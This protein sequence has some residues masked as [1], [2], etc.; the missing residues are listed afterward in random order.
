MKTYASGLV[1]ALFLWPLAV[2]A[3]GGDSA[4]GGAEHAPGGPQVLDTPVPETSEGSVTPYQVP[5]HVPA[6]DP[7]QTGFASG[8]ILPDF[9]DSSATDQRSYLGALYVTPDQGLQGVHV[10]SVIPGSPAARA[11]F[12]GANTPQPKGPNWFR[13][14][15]FAL[16][17]SPA[18]AFAIPL[19][20]AHHVYTNRTVAAPVDLPGDLI[21]AVDDKP[22]RDAQAFSQVLSSYEPGTRVSFS[23][24]RA[25]KPLQLSATLEREPF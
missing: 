7:S 22:V 21:V 12:I 25:G 2:C 16:S 9:P 8:D 19:T 10:L 18:G 17:M 23:I 20:I 6:Q 3:Q 24:I 5:G 13:V 15:V 4:Q 11:G 1:A 14:A